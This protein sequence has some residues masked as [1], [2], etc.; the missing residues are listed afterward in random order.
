MNKTELERQLRLIKDAA[1][2]CLRV[3]NESMPE[4]DKNE[5]AIVKNPA[6]LAVDSDI[7]F[8]MQARAFFKKHAKDMSGPKTFT[9]MVAYFVN[10]KGTEEA[11]LTDIQGE[12]SKMKSII[13]PK[14]SPTFAVRSRENDWIVSPKNSLY[15]LRPN[16]KEIFK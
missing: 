13:K 11:S 7:D 4:D 10:K 15:S 14:F 6:R 16:W 3:L 5:A 9:L 8:S 1:E 2:K 12:W